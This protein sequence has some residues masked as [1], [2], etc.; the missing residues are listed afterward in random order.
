MKHKKD[1]FKRVNEQICFKCV[2]PKFVSHE[3]LN[4]SH[5]KNHIVVK[6][7]NKNQKRCEIKNGSKWQ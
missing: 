2:M 1:M 7:I 6:W 5:I 3:T 4:K